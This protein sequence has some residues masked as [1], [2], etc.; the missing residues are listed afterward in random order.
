MS[1]WACAGLQARERARAAPRGPAARARR[2]PA[3]I[4]PPP[5]L[6]YPLGNTGKH[7]GGGGGCEA[8][9]VGRG[10][11][12]GAVGVRKR[13]RAARAA[14]TRS[15]AAGWLL[16]AGCSVAARVAVRCVGRG[17]EQVG[18]GGGVGDLH[19]HHPPAAKGVLVHLVVIAR[20]RGRAGVCVRRWV[21]GGAGWREVVQQAGRQDPPPP[22]LTPQ[23][24]HPC[25]YRP[26]P[27]P[28]LTT[29]S[30]L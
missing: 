8:G 11:G 13:W 7:K 22:P 16:L 30:H 2:P 6:Q 18:G 3:R 1:N 24:P 28:P 4:A 17:V 10:G 14:S 23:T 29:L 26:G 15:A 25:A 19:L 20:S 21:G 9:G 27:A 12:G 5:L